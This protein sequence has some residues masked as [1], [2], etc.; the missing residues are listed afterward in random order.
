MKQLLFATLVALGACAAPEPPLSYPPSARDRMLRIAI[1]E[2]RDWGSIVLAPDAAAPTTPAESQTDNFPRVLAYWRAVPDEDGAI[3]RNRTR[4]RAG[5]PA[6]WSEPAWSAAFI[7]YVLRAAGVDAREFPPTAAH[8]FYIDALI[9]DAA[10]FPAAA[11]FIPH[12]PAAHA[13]REGDLVCADRSAAPLPHW[14]AR[15]A[16]QGRFRPMHCDIVIHTRRGYVEAI[17]GNVRDAVT[18]TRFPTDASG[19][20]LP[21]PAGGAAWFAVFENRLGRLPPFSTP[22]NQ[23]SP[24]S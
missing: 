5:S 14:H 23:R 22:S 20:L 13:P 10:R 12:D 9:A 6:L 11:P 17:G 15:I 18:L 19:V 3:A 4:Y 1:A 8:A 7:S 24:I 21:R 16:E 2:W